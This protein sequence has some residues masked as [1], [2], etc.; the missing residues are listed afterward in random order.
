MTRRIGLDEL[1][2]L[3]LIVI[4][5]LSRPL[6]KAF[7]ARFMVCGPPAGRKSTRLCGEPAQATGEGRRGKDTA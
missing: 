1:I 5:Q 2:D 7:Y 4:N 6:R 3:P